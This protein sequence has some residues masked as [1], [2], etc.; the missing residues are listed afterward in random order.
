VPLFPTEALLKGTYIATH[1][2]QFLH[3]TVLS[4]VLTLH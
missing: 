2:S 1:Y 3:D 4:E